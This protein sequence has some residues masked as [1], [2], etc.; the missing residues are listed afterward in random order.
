MPFAR[1]EA[2]AA[3]RIFAGD[4]YREFRAGGTRVA[5]MITQTVT[6][7]RP[8]RVMSRRQLHAFLSNQDRLMRFLGWVQKHVFTNP[9]GN[10]LLTAALHT[11]RVR[12]APMFTFGVWFNQAR[13][14]L[15]ARL[16]AERLEDPALAARADR[17]VELALA[18]PAEH[19][20]WPSVCL[21]AGGEVFWKRGTRAF[22]VADSFHLPDMATTGFHLL[23]WAERIGPDPRVLRRCEDLAGALRP[24]QGADGSFPSW[25]RERDG[26]LEAEPLLARC[27]AAAAPA[28]FLARLHRVR[29]DAPARDAAARAL[30][31]VEAHVMPE[32]RWNDFELHY[33]CAGRPTAED[34]PDPFTG[35][36]PAS[37]LG[38]YWTARAALDLWVVEGDGRWLGLARR[39]LGRLSL[40]QQVWDHPRVSIDTFG[41]FGVMNVDAEWN[42][43]RQGLFAPLY[44]DMYRAT[45]EPE[46]FERGLA[47]MRACYTTLLAEEHREVAPGNLR[48]FHARNQG[49]VVENFGHSG[50]DEAANGY[51]APDW[52]GG[53]SLYASGTAR[54]LFG[55]AYV[56]AASGQVFS[57]DLFAV[58]ALE[59]GPAAVRLEVRDPPG[60]ALRLVVD[61]ARPET[62]LWV[63]GR[64]A[65][66]SNGGPGPFRWT[67]RKESTS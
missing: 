50:R 61:N 22:A 7:P 10:R 46:F 11:G 3:G 44:L 36:L 6:A 24:L 51:L 38:M 35:N 12:V 47:A 2:L 14:A 62:R 17:M 45:G 40:Y 55:D 39:A 34:G 32:E 31:F 42:D 53:T 25:V 20:L 59:V 5:G 66:A 41:G 27:A 33:S 30:A 23:E 52:G 26:A 18:A 58:R 28:M 48:R 67:A 19:G 43:A 29:G 57:L 15:G 13:T 4:L 63:N 49:A 54:A 37:T 16:A 21:V 56:N 65:G 8:P 60:H 1:C 9:V 64:E